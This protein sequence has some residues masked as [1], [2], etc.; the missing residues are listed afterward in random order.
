[1]KTCFCSTKNNT[2][3]TTI[4]NA[5]LVKCPVI[6][7]TS[8]SLRHTIIAQPRLL[9]CFSIR[10]ERAPEPPPPPQPCPPAVQRLLLSAVLML[11]V[12]SEGHAGFTT[13]RHPDALRPKAPE[14][15][16]GRVHRV[17][18]GSA[19]LGFHMKSRA[20]TQG[21]DDKVSFFFFLDLK[22]KNAYFDRETLSLVRQKTG[23]STL[24]G[25]TAQ[26]EAAQIVRRLVIL[27][28]PPVSPDA[29]NYCL[30]FS[31]MLIHYECLNS[32]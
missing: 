2:K 11:S 3:Y 20:D 29:F 6:F 14:R 8:D 9:S 16:S 15:G 27:C 21:T 31:T 25:Q 1:M 30:L 12:K 17:R 4:Q 5:Q 28:E 22:K 13:T 23:N 18:S 19:S 24:V 32:P 10:L 7:V 26:K